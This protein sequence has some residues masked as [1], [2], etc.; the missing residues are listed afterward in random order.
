MSRTLTHPRCCATFASLLC[1]QGHFYREPHAGRVAV[2]LGAGNQHFLAL[3]D[4]LHMAVVEG[5]C[6]LL[7]YHPQMAVRG[8][9]CG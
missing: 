1:P 8:R 3:A 7:K 5:C 2:V 4:A 6:V 9:L